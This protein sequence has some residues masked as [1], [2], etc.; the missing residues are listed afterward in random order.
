MS[1][2]GQEQ[3]FLLGS[4]VQWQENSTNA[5]IRPRWTLSQDSSIGDLPVQARNRY[6]LW[7]QD[8]INIC[9]CSAES[10]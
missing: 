9:V 8:Y 7:A 10:R 4:M 3:D 1:V 5:A 6:L 2:K